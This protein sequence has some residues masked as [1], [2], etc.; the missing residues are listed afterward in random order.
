MKYFFKGELL[1]E[2]FLSIPRLA[3]KKKLHRSIQNM[4]VMHWET[5]I[6]LS[7]NVAKEETVILNSMKIK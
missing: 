2:F 6:N 4:H 1:E 5:M 7:Y 3:I